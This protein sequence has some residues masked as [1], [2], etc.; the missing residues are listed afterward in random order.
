VRNVGTSEA[1]SAAAGLEQMAFGRSSAAPSLCIPDMNITLELGVRG[2]QRAQQE[3]PIGSLQSW[4]N[5]G[6]CVIRG[7]GVYD[8]SNKP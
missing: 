8:K 6:L 1:H 2:I 7:K 4:L 5:F 3:N